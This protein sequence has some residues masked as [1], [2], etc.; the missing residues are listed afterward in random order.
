MHSRSDLERKST[1]LDEAVTREREIS[2]RLLATEA[3][4]SSF[5]ADRQAFESARQLWAEEKSCY[6]TRIREFE[7]IRGMLDESRRQLAET[8]ENARRA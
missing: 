4:L 8:R 5:V 3:Q 2:A 1:M 6:I 7:G